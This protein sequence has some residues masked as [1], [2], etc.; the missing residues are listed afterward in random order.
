MQLSRCVDSTSKNRGKDFKNSVKINLFHRVC[1][2]MCSKH[3]KMRVTGG[4][5]THTVGNW[6]QE[7]DSDNKMQRYLNKTDS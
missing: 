3:I 5:V 4:E 1:A 6:C 7:K 2:R